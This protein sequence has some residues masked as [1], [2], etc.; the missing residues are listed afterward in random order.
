MSPQP[1]NPARVLL[2]GNYAELLGTRAMLL[3]SVGM[4]ADIAVGIHDFRSRTADAG[5][6]YSAVVC[7]YTATDAE[8]DEII[9]I[10]NQ[11]RTAFLKLEPLL[12]PTD[13]INQALNVI[14]R[15][16]SRL[17]GASNG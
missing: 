6:L 14:G 2:F 8:C 9:A 16:R 17:D 1:S 3:Q 10:T 7:C 13:L 4:I 12:S 15:G 5:S 11:N